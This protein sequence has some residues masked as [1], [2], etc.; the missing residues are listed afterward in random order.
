MSKRLYRSIT[1]PIRKGLSWEEQWRGP[2]DGLILCWET[3][4]QKA[5]Q[6]PELAASVKRGELAPL[7]WKGGVTK[8]VQIDRK[9]GTL[10]YLAEWQGLRNEDLD[11]VMDGERVI[12]CTKTGQAV[13]F[14]A[15]LILE[16]E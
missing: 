10:N 7:G 14:S 12:V 2:D 1:E 16:E 15:A 9:N 3:G 8:K 11:V 6:N 4:R 13:V 5:A